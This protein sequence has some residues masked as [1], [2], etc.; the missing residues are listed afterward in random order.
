MEFTIKTKDA[1]LDVRV[2]NERVIDGV[3][4]FDVV[5]NS[6]TP[7]VPKKF[8]VTWKILNHN[9]FSVWKPKSSDNVR[10]VRPNW[11]KQWQT[12]RLASWMPVIQANAVDGTNTATLALSDAATPTRVGLGATEQLA[13]LEA[14][15]E[16]FTEP[17]DPIDTYRATVRF[18]TRKIKFYDALYDVAAWWEKDCGYG[19]AHVPA[20]ARDAV[21]SLWYS[22]HQKLEPDEIVRQCALSKALGM[23]TVIIDDGWQTA[24]VNLGYKFCGDWELCPDKIP[25]MKELCDRLHEIGVKVVLW[26]SVPYMGVGAK[27]FEKFKDMLL[28]DPHKQGWASLDPRYKEVRE[29]LK[30]IY[31]NA[32]VNYGLDGFKLDFIDAFKL[33]PAS[34]E[35]DPR[36]D[37]ASLESAVDTLMSEVNA[38]LCAINPDVMLEFRQ[39]YVGPCIRKYGNMLRVSDCPN[40]SYAN[41]M[42][43]LD[44]RLTSGNTA[45]HSDMVM[46]NYT[47]DVESAALQMANILYCVP[48][49]SVRFDEIPEDHKKMVKFYLDL[50]NQNRELLLDGRLEMENPEAYYSRAWAHDGKKAIISLYTKPIIDGSFE[51]VIAVNA[52]PSSSVIVKGYN[53]KKYRVVNCMGEAVSEGV[54]NGALAEIDMPLCS[55]VYID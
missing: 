6:D 27:N 14:A 29:Y 12:S 38:E 8:T 48:Q 30:A 31:K 52:S 7:I 10:M 50:W 35:Y 49:V 34:M 24:D 54:I 26:Y 42:R 3:T 15:I 39:S 11:S 28:D 32:L 25:S 16:F 1:G 36:R 37:C 2:E 55:V 33:T 47:E 40:D 23:D 4:F 46:W 19:T 20:A 22:Y 17:V 5:M 51:S 44:L 43:M 53:D 41:R 45:V 13:E 9:V 21:N 18:D